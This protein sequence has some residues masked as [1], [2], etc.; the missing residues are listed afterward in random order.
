LQRRGVRL[1]TRPLAVVGPTL[2]AGFLGTRRLH[3][4]LIRGVFGVLMDMPEGLPMAEVLK[5]VEER[6]P[7]TPDEQADYPS[8]PGARRFERTIRF[9]TIGP[10]KAGWLVKNK[11]QWSLTDDGRTAYTTC[12]DPDALQR[13]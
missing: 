6:V 9:A 12:T 1:A 3:G 2:Y 10:V 4:E 11:G 8:T 7:P 5:A 13:E